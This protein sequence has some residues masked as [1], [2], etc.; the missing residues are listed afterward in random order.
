[1]TYD[2]VGNRIEKTDPLGRST[3]FQYDLLRR[4]E[5]TRFSSPFNYVIQYTHD[6]NGNLI[7]I[8]RQTSNPLDPWQTVSLTYTYTDKIEKRI[9]PHGDVKT[10]QYDSADRLSSVTN[11]M[12]QTTEY[13]YDANGRV[14]RII[15]AL[16]N[17]AA[18]KTYTPN[19]QLKDIK[20]ANGNITNYGYDDFDRLSK[21]LY[22]DGS[23]ETFTYDAVGN[24][25]QKRTRA[26]D[27]ITYQYDDLNRLITKSF[28][29]P[30]NTDYVY[31]LTGRLVEVTD[32]NGTLHYD[33]DADG[34]LAKVTYPGNKAV[35][36]EY[37]DNGN[38]TRLTYPDGFF[39]TYHYDELNRLIEVLAQGSTSLARYEYDALTRRIRLTYGNG[40]FCTYAYEIDNDLISLDHQ[41]LGS[42]SSFS[43]TYDNNGN[44]TSFTSSD[45]R[46]VYTPPTSYQLDYVS[47]VLNQYTTVGGTSFTFD[48]N[49]NLTSDGVNT[50]IYDTENR[51]IQVITP[52]HTATYVYDYAGRR[53]AKTVDS[54]T[55]YYIYDGAH[56]IMEYDSN[57]QMLRRYAYGP[58]IDQPI[59]LMTPTAEYFYHFDGLGSVIALSDSPGNVVETYAYSPYGKVS[60]AS[61]VG[62]TYF[63]TGRFYDYETG[64]YYYRARNYDPELGRF[65]QID[66]EGYRADMNLYVYVENNPVNFVDP[67]GRDVVSA[68]PHPLLMKNIGAGQG[69]KMA[70]FPPDFY[71][72]VQPGEFAENWQDGQLVGITGRNYDG[73][74]YDIEISPDGKKGQDTKYDPKT[75]YIEQTTWDLEG[76]VPPGMDAQEY[77]D[78]LIKEEEE[79]KKKREEKKHE[80]KK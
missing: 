60:Q 27:I 17:I 21:T 24:L 6:P 71:R 7:Q 68:P 50:Y 55:I 40:T 38:R 11:A 49:G 77:V 56:V 51:M 53:I 39:I 42:S 8:A 43:Y 26:G 57:G 69:E 52:E 41:F 44:C 59:I 3:T 5:R 10:Y 29:G 67:L 34:R 62:N 15:G 61:S 18:E 58:G 9:D 70:S 78:K 73:S 37:D 1:M 46:F 66:P 72:E 45:D 36:Y 20:D 48:G 14:Y 31:D 65:L 25:T 47:N 76:D 4:F 79:M 22:P 2:N 33:L 23:F 32:F 13:R 80:D 12:G 19:G 75:E 54:K 64:L 74:Y 28:P 35:Q 16:G 63:Y 30:E